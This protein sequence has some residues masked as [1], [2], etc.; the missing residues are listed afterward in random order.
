M[1]ASEGVGS[2]EVKREAKGKDVKAAEGDLL[3]LE[4]VEMEEKRHI[5]D[6]GC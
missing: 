6:R 1:E 5:A 3:S 4:G 2:L